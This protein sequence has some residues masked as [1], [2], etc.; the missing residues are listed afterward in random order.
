[1]SAR[2]NLAPIT[3][4]RASSKPA[5]PGRRLAATR[6]RPSDALARFDGRDFE[7][8]VG[9]AFRRQGFRVAGFGTTGFGGGRDG[10]ADLGLLKNG[11]RFLVQCRSWRKLEIGLTVMRE[12]CALLGVQGAHGG[13]LLTSGRVTPEARALAARS[14]VRLY[15]GPRLAQLL[16]LR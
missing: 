1:L 13:F 2:R 15:E 8:R 5:S 7:R 16:G 9:D 10:A 11:E 14:R 6:T 4:T 3:E 12:F